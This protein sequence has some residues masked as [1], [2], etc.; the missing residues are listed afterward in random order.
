MISATSPSSKNTKSFVSCAIAKGSEAAKCSS[1]PRPIKSGDLLL[2]IIIFSL[3][4]S[5]NTSQKRGAD[6]VVTYENEVVYTASSKYSS[7]SELLSRL[8]DGQSPD[9]IIFSSQWCAACK[10]LD[11]IVVER[12]WRD[13]VIILNMDE[14]W[15]GYVAKQLG[16]S[17]IPAGIVTNDGG[18]T[19]TDIF[20]G[21]GNIFRI[22]YQELESKK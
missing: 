13:D 19:K 8:N 10:K 14:R 12:G 4:A 1:S 20:Y 21:P 16:I 11:K 6:L 15:V 22:I 9:I 7:E 2:A 3:F 5:C 18:E 17:A